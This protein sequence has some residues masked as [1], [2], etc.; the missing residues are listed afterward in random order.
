MKD[1]HDEIIRQL[2]IVFEDGAKTLAA[3]HMLS[4]EVGTQL[5]KHK[6]SWDAEKR[7]IA[8]TVEKEMENSFL[9]SPQKAQETTLRHQQLMENFLRD[10]ED[11]R[12]A[13]C[14]NCRRKF[15]QWLHAAASS[16]LLSSAS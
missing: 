1:C 10:L 8:N 9:V 6:A 16:S 12:K 15:L 4:Y 2:L 3:G 13:V 11:R 5:Q 7:R 14:R